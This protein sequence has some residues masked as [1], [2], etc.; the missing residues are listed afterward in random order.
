[1]EEL[2]YEI[3]QV[4]PEVTNSTNNN[5]YVENKEEVL[6]IFKTEWNNIGL[7][8]STDIFL[9]EEVELFN[10]IEDYVSHKSK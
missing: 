5:L 2:G 3:N 1:M 8:E 6:N 9:K 10:M 7:K 4:R